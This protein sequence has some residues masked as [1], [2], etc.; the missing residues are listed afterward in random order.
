MLAS[1]LSRA[2]DAL[3]ADGWTAVSVWVL[4]GNAGARAFYAAA[5]F[6][7]DGA[8]KTDPVGSCERAEGLPQIRLRRSVT[9]P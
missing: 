5:G 6:S 4:A 8:V 2:L 7:P 1:P 3:A 9:V